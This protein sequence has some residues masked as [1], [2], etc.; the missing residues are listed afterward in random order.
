[1]KLSV[2]FAGI[3]ALLLLSGCASPPLKSQVASWDESDK[4]ADSGADSPDG[5]RH[6]FWIMKAGAD[7]FERKFG[8]VVDGHLQ[9]M[10]VPPFAPYE[11]KV[12]SVFS[13]DGKSVASWISFLNTSTNA[14]G[15][16]LVA[17]TEIL[18]DGTLFKISN[19]TVETPPTFGAIGT[20]WTMLVRNPLTKKVHVVTD[21]DLGPGRDFVEMKSAQF[22]TY[23]RETAVTASTSPNIREHQV[24]VGETLSSIAAKYRTTTRAL[25]N[26][27]SLKNANHVEV[28]QRLIIPEGEGTSSTLPPAREHQVAKGETLSGIAK[29]YHTTARAIKEANNLKDQNHIKVGQRLT[30]PSE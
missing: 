15:A 9:N 28:G 20:N 22:G 14:V 23:Q 18:I 25:M 6:A 19:V 8:A 30:I 29:K 27:N 24:A 5:Q 3:L 12:G 13:A 17:Q 16:Q 4:L 2:G 26:A 10:F 1:M 7:D 11:G 21:G